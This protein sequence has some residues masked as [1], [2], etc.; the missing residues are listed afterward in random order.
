MAGTG[1]NDWASEN[2][3]VS[4]KLG[5]VQDSVMTRRYRIAA[6]RSQQSPLLGDAGWRDVVQCVVLHTDVSVFLWFVH[7]VMKVML[8]VRAVTGMIVC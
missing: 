5:L 7:V 2:V 3:G 1:G 4:Q 8:P 6:A